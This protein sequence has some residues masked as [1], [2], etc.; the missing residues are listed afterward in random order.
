MKKLFLCVIVLSISIITKSQTTQVEIIDLAVNPGIRADMQ[1]D[2]TDLIVLFKINNVNIA[3]KAYYYFGTVQ[4]AGDVLSVTGNIIEQSATYYLQVNGVQKEI[5]G[6]TATAFIKL[7]NV[8]NAG[9][10][11]LTVFVEDNN[12]LI[13]D[14][15]YFHK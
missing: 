4:D 7:S 8:Q 6:Y 15:L 10:H 12:G 13:T 3:A 2:T 5:L 1:S 14:K 11:Y 9:F